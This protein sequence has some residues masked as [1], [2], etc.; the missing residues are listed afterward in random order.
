[1]PELPEVETVVRGLRASLVGRT[2]TGMT[3]HWP[4]TIVS[5]E[6]DEFAARIV[7]RRVQAVRRRGKY[8]LIDLDKGHLLIHLKMSGRLLLVPAS[9]PLDEYTHTIFDLNDGH[10]LRFRDVRKFGRVYLVESPEE[11]TGHLGPEPLEEAFTLADF[12]QVL[13]RRTGRLKSL[14]LNQEFVA[15]LGNIYADESLYAAHLHPLRAADSLT[16]EEQARLYEAIRAVLRRAIV[17]RGTTLDDTG[18]VDAQGEPGAYQAQIAVYG[19]AGEPCPTCNT[20]IE[21]LVVGGRSTHFCP[22]CQP[23]LSDC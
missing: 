1:M 20:S 6:L 8:V 13:G 2:I 5:P 15:G 16:A 23:A 17:S 9:E 12:R 4:R 14:L 19:R 7:D 18:Y 10:Q 21:R 3:A 11:V 22:R